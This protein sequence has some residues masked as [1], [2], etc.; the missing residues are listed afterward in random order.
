MQPAGL[1]PAARSSLKYRTKKVAK[2]HHLGTIAQLCRTIGPIF[3]TKEHIDN[4]KKFL[5]ISMPSTCPQNM[6]NFG[7]LAAEIGYQFGA[8]LQ[9]STAFASWRRYCTAVK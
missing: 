2:N 6:V 7:P 1:K 5:S 4:R 9:I 3:A 8:P